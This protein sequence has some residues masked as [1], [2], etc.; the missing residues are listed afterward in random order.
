MTH[1]EFE[2]A[3]ESLAIGPRRHDLLDTY[4]RWTNDPMVMRGNG[5][6]EP[7]EREALRLPIGTATSSIEHPIAAAEF[8]IGLGEEGRGRGLAAPAA[9][10]RC[11]PAVEWTKS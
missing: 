5:R 1:P 10:V 11:G 2:R 7:E 3:T 6:F 8:F 4:L 9:A